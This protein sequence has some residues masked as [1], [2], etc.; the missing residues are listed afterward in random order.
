MSLLS[1]LQQ[2]FHAVVLEKL[3]ARS[4][5][6]EVLAGGEVLSRCTCMK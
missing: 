3:G 4:K 1:G 6:Y 2:A 5:K